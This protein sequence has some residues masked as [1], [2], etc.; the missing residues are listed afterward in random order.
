MVICDQTTWVTNLSL[1]N[2]GKV[3]NNS[4]KALITISYVGATC[5]A[6]SH[7]LVNKGTDSGLEL[8]KDSCDLYEKNEL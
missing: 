2:V 7:I 1:Y 8:T 4:K 5:N 3:C 6:T